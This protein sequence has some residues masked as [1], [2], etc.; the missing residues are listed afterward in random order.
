MDTLVSLVALLTPEQWAS[1]LPGIALVVTALGSL[2][3]AIISGFAL[4]RSGKVLVKTERIEKLTNGA[5][6]AAAADKKALEAKVEGLEQ[7]LVD[8]LADKVAAA[9]VARQAATDVRAE[10]ERTDR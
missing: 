4:H 8:A 5:K 9:L 2:I 1:T 6:D 3:A 7:R 10:R